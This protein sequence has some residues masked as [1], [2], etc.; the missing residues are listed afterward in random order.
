M[1]TINTS[2]GV[3]GGSGGGDSVSQ[4]ASIAKQ[5]V[6]LQEQLKSMAGDTTLDEDQKAKQQ[7]MIENQIMM[8][9]AQLAQIQQQQAEKAAEQQEASK[10]ADSGSSKMADGVNRPTEDNQLN[11]YI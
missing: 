7:Q 8:L 6:R 11:V 3:S 10:A 1:T 9:E 5:I 2:S 4:T